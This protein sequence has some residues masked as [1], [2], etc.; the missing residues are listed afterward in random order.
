MRQYGTSFGFPSY[1]DLKAAYE[2]APADKAREL[3]GEFIRAAERVVEPK[4]EEIV[5]SFRLHLAIEALLE[6][7]KA[8]AVAIDCLGGFGRGDLPAYPCVSFSRLNDEGRYGVCECDLESTMTQLL[9]TPFSRMPG[10]V[11][12]PVFDTSR[13]EVIHA[14]CVSARR[15]TGLDRAPAPYRVRSHLEDHK[16]VSMQVLA[17]AGGPVT[18]ARFADPKKM[19]VSRGEAIGN[20]D[21]ERG[22]RTKIRTRVPDAGRLLANWSAALNTGP[23]MP[24]TRDLLHRVV[25][26]GDHIRDIERL[27]RLLAFQVVHEA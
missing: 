10:F 12:D 24:G 21:D 22:C 13:N 15:L 2:A 27:G 20:A 1:L 23:E 4:P 16:G 26:Y 19:M 6:A 11:S 18:V 7:E 8:N 9:V 14:H 25:F 5:D 17:P 3:A